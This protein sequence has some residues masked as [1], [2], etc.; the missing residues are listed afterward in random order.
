MT[1]PGRPVPLPV[2]LPALATALSKV[3]DMPCVGWVLA[4]WVAS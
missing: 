2:N 1:G 3:E 4:G